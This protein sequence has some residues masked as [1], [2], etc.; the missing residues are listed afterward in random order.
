M[1]PPPG[2]IRV[3]ES[4]SEKSWSIFAESMGGISEEREEPLRKNACLLI[5]VG[6]A[7]PILLFVREAFSDGKRTL[8]VL[9]TAGGKTQQEVPAPPVRRARQGPIK[10]N[11]ALPAQRGV[12]NRAPPCSR[13]LGLV[14][15][16]VASALHRVVWS[17][18]APLVRLWIQRT[19]KPDVI[20]DR[21]AF[22]QGQGLRRPAI[23][24]Q[25]AKLRVGVLYAARAAEAATAIARQVVAVVAETAANTEAILSSASTTIGCLPS[26]SGRQPRGDASLPVVLAAEDRLYLLGRRDQLG[27][28]ARREALAGMGLDIAA[29]IGQLAAGGGRLPSID[30]RERILELVVQG[31]LQA[32]GE[33]VAVDRGGQGADLGGRALD[34]GREGP[35]HRA[36][37]VIAV[38]GGA[39]DLRG[40]GGGG[41][42]GGRGAADQGRGAISTFIHHPGRRVGYPRCF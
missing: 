11:L 24:R 7:Y 3:E 21:A 10:R 33:V 18:V 27:G 5:E 40:A 26:S 16:D 19:R 13:R 20:T 35:A 36:V 28:L 22:E 29:E 6:S 1:S 42:A 41:A 17:L 31:V 15:P 32:A 25:W 4:R 38:A 12:I 30:N 34:R 9:A 2:C 8:P 23:A 39:G 14:G 37:R